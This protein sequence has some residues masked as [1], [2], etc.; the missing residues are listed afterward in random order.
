MDGIMPLER[1]KTQ[2]AT[3]SMVPLLW[4]SQKDKTIVTE[5]RSAV[6][7]GSGWGWVSPERDSMRVFWGE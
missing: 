4:H 5:N 3:H 2:K 6:T 1:S 7:R